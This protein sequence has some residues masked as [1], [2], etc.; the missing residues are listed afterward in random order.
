MIVVQR[1]TLSLTNLQGLWFAR[2]ETG[3]LE[4]SA[5]ATV[6]LDGMEVSMKEVHGMVHGVFKEPATPDK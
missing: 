4:V 5:H 1:V 3:D 6:C 2:L